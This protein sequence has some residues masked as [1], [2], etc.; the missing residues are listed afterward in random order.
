MRFAIVSDIHGNLEAFLE[1]MEDMKHLAVEE[2]VSLG[3]NIGYGPD[4]EEVLHR[5]VAR[6]I[7][8]IMGNHELGIVDPTFLEWFNTSARR[9]LLITT[10]LLSPWSLEFIRTLKP[11]YELH[12]ALCVHGF[13]PES[14]TTYLFQVNEGELL[15]HFRSSPFSITFVGH[16]HELGLI[17]FDG[18]R[19]QHRSLPVGL[20]TLEADR[21]YIVNAGSVGQ[22]RDG[23]NRAKYL[24]WD[25]RSMTLEVRAVAYDIATTA[26]KILERGFPRINADRLW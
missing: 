10:D 8:S 12:G 25:D 18:V 24:V 23:S 26:R 3:D 4:P 20:T 19:V 6:G 16:T 15:R 14:V 11:A 7:T 9:S 22:P 2:V 21:K 17:V 5:L 13:P 1:V